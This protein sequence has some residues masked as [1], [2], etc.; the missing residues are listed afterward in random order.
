[1]EPDLS[2][3]ESIINYKFDNNTLLK[4]AMTHRSYAAE[5]KIPTD[6]QR[7][8]FLGDA[9]IEIIVT[10]YLFKL[11]PEK[12]EGELTTLRSALVQKNTLAE[13]G[14]EMNLH[15]FIFLGKGEKEAGGATRSSTLCDAFEALIGAM[16]L[17]ANLETVRDFLLNML[18]NIFPKPNDFSLKLNPKG[19]LQEVTQREWNVKPE[20]R[21]KKTTGPQHNLDY[22]VEAY[23][24]N[25]AYGVGKGKSI[26]S[27]ESEAAEATLEMIKDHTISE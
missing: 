11:Y 15:E 21:I 25:K 2:K 22:V 9:V 8:E 27:A 23:I 17:D 13:L 12:Q 16:Y 10:E 4:K 5:K 19:L 26:K 18:T 3:L 1:M 20:Y 7:L 14:L 24:K 6:N